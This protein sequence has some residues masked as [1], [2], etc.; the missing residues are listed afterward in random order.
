MTVCAAPE[1]VP[2]VPWQLAF[3]RRMSAHSASHNG[4]VVAPAAGHHRVDRNLLGR[5]HDLSRRDGPEDFVSGQTGGEEE[6]L[7]QLGGGRDDGEAVG[8][9]PGVIVLDQREAAVIPVLAR[10]EPRH[11]APCRG[12]WITTLLTPG[13]YFCTASETT[14]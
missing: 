4:R 3:S 5:D 1:R 14:T 12:S 8:P 6:L 13:E 9:S 2:V 10:T 7:D 11:G